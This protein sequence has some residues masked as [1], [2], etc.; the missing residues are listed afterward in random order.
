MTRRA[1]A[2]ALAAAVALVLLTPWLLGLVAEQR[3]RAGLEALSSSGYRVL[4]HEYRRDWLRS[5]ALLVIA[6]PSNNGVEP[7]R[8]QVASRI[9]HGPR[10]DAWSAWPPAVAVARSRLT[11]VGGPRRLPP[12]T[13]NTAF[14]IGGSVVADFG[15]PGITYSGRAGA[16]H[17]LDGRGRVRFT[18]SI[19]AWR[20]R[21]ALPLLEAVD[22]DDRT[23]VLR[24]LAW[25]FEL[26]NLS[27]G[28]PAGRLMLRLD[29]LQLEAAPDQPLL[30]LGGA[31]FNL[32]TAVDKGQAQGEAEVRIDQL[33][34][35]HADFAPSIVRIGVTGVDAASL[36]ALLDA[37]REL[38]AGNLQGSIRGL[39]IGRLLTRSLP[40]ILSASPRLTLEQLELTT[41]N[42]AVTASGQLTLTNERGQVAGRAD[43]PAAYWAHRLSGEARLSVPQA[44]V[45]QLLVDEQRKRVQ[46]E[47]RNLGE[48]A[49][50]LPARLAE[51]VEAAAQASLMSLLRHGWLVADRGRLSASAVISDGVLR[52]NGKP[53]P[54][55]RWTTP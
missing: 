12:L 46:Q 53:L 36:A 22:S 23:L 35:N 13:L 16:L 27:N 6:P 17:L 4:Q 42:G 9:A 34:L 5:T 28:V 49:A 55:N 44:L 3:Y 41:P 50:P 37:L 47:L 18:S 30:T 8:L 2:A 38:N 26:H 51:E 54:I 29:A 20:G 25:E 14:S 39:A 48:P 24:G 31:L 43:L 7:P 1:I 10:G 11:V 40:E 52:L 33:T 19:D 15:L 45:L 21:G 32:E